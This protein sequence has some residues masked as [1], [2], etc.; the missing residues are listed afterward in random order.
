MTL[1][2]LVPLLAVG[3]L[4]AALAIH[5]H[6]GRW[7]TGD[8]ATNERAAGPSA[9]APACSSATSTPAWRSSSSPPPA[10]SPS[11]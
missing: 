10:P 7:P 9:T 4:L 3:G 6:V 11:P 1:T 2:A 5:V 8:A